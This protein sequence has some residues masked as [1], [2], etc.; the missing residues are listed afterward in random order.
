MEFFLFRLRSKSFAAVFAS[1]KRRRAFDR[2]LAAR[3]TLSRAIDERNRQSS[4]LFARLHSGK[5]EILTAAG[6]SAN[7]CERRLT[8]K[9]AQ[10][11]LFA[12]PPPPSSS[13][14]LARAHD[15]KTASLVARESPAP[16]N[17]K[18]N[19]ACDAADDAPPHCLLFESRLLSRF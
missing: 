19:A 6:A 3:R 10:N 13:L 18:M 5:S 2:L 9:L 4:L 16:L 11:L 1:C 17:L 14:R 12:P 7:T 8:A 15:E